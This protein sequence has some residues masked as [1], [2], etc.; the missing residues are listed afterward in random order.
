MKGKTRWAL[1]PLLWAAFFGEQGELSA[2]S[3]TQMTSY[4][5]PSGAYERLTTQDKTVVADSPAKLAVGGISTPEHRL[6]VLGNPAD[7]A[8]MRVDGKFKLLLYT[9]LPAI[10]SQAGTLYY[11]QGSERPAMIVD[12]PTSKNL[13]FDGDMPPPI[14]SLPPPP[15]PPLNVEWPAIQTAVND[16]WKGNCCA[17]SVSQCWRNACGGPPHGEADTANLNATL[18]Y[19]QATF[20]MPPTTTAEHEEFTSKATCII[21]GVGCPPGCNKNNFV[22]SKGCGDKCERDRVKALIEDIFEDY[23][24]GVD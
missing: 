16:I 24:E 21:S 10:Y 1:C 8:N 15:P 3:E 13:A 7:P 2:T 11:N 18:D 22:C 5:S 9:S 4:P 23:I 14:I 12:G 6:H 20:T 19:V 17:P